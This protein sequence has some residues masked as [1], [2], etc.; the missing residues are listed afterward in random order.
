MPPRMNSGH[1]SIVTATLAMVAMVDP[2]CADQQPLPQK[3]D[4]TVVAEGISSNPSAVDVR[5]S[6][7]ELQ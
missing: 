7:G 5:T 2:V 1:F 4:T 3:P 6:T